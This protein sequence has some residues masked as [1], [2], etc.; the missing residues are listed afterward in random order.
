MKKS[1]LGS[2]I[3]F[4]SCFTLFVDAQT[5][6]NQKAAELVHGANLLRIDENRKTVSFVKLNVNDQFS[7]AE[8]KLWLE[9]AVLKLPQGNSFQ[10][11]KSEYDNIQ[12]KHNRFKQYYNFVP[13]ENG[14]YYVHV[15]NGV[16]Q[17]ANGEVYNV[18]DLNVNPKLSKSN[19]F[20]LA[21]AYVPATVYKDQ[22]KAV[23]FI[24]QLSKVY[25]YL[26]DNKDSELVSDRKSVV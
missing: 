23:D 1:Y 10:L 24:N 4:L 19:A 7:E 3:L 6:E 26:L 9:Q 18:K 11:L 20:A 17:S 14:I 8:Q 15:K 2:L 12:T 25:R 5:F 13:V 22:D 21:L 16:V